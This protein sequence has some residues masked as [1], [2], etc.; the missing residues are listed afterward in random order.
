MNL[1]FAL[2]LALLLGACAG[3]L[4]THTLLLPATA[5]GPNNWVAFSFDLS[6]SSQTISELGPTT[7]V[8][9]YTRFGCDPI[10]ASTLSEL[11]TKP[12]AASGL[13][14]RATV[15][16]ESVTVELEPMI[17]AGTIAV[18]IG[19]RSPDGSWHW[20]QNAVIVDMNGGSLTLPVDAT[21]ADAISVFPSGANVKS[22]SVGLRRY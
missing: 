12:H 11:L 9:V 6:S 21:D 17:V 20:P 15:H 16:L 2:P 14:H 5:G 3:P 7:A 18:C 13:P 1:R 4:E 8:N 22:V 10:E 19:T